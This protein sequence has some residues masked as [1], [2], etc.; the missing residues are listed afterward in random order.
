[1]AGPGTTF[2]GPVMS[3]TKKDA[4]GNGPANTGLCQLIQTGTITQNGAAAVTIQFVLPSNS[5]IHDVVVDTGVAWNAGTSATF[6]LGATAG[7]ADYASGV[8]TAATGRTRPTFTAAQLTAM[9]NISNNTTVYATITP[10]GTAPTN[11]TTYVA[12]EYIQTVQLTSGEA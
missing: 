8:S 4:D 12:I 3:G 1:M 9:Q 2:S 5:I 7:G 11:G 10:S 6:T